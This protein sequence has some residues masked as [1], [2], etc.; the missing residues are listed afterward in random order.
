MQ[1]PGVDVP[2]TLPTAAP[3]GLSEPR[4]AHPWES[5]DLTLQAL[6]QKIL[7]DRLEA[8]KEFCRLM[9]LASLTA[10]PIYLL[11]FILSIP[12]DQDPGRLAGL[13]ILLPC[14]L[15]L[16]AVL[17]FAGGLLPVKVSPPLNF[18]DQIEAA[19]RKIIG[20]RNQLIT[21]GLFSF[22]IACLMGMIVI[23]KGHL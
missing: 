8:G 9:L 19:Y 10:I 21:T 6:G 18:S 3:R 13:M 22:G 16:G 7:F 2:G 5:H 17:A 15:F 20:R 12:Y 23:V 4:L 1:S 14:V 11:L